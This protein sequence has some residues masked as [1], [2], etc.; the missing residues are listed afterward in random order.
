MMAYDELGLE[1]LG[2]EKGGLSAAYGVKLYFVGC[3]KL[4]E[5]LNVEWG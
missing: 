2:D 3:H 1:R 4:P 5:L